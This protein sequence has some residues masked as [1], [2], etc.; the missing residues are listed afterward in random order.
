MEEFLRI[1][2]TFLCVSSTHRHL[3]EQEFNGKR[4][5]VKVSLPF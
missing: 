5:A 4:A 1:K 2:L 3:R